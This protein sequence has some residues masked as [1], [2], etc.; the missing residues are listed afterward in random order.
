M[1]SSH[2][3]G[4]IDPGSASF[5]ILDSNIQVDT[6]PVGTSPN[7]NHITSDAGRNRIASSITMAASLCPRRVLALP[8]FQFP[9]PPLAHPVAS[10]QLRFRARDEG[11]SRQQP[12]VGF[13]H[14]PLRSFH[15]STPL[16]IGHHFDTLKFVQRLKNDGF[17]EEQAVALMKILGDVMEERSVSYRPSLATSRT[18][19]YN[20]PQHYYILLSLL[21]TLALLP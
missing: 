14:R 13:I 8:R 3:G 2:A 7:A 4:G 17:T 18:F 21:P 20:G 12:P 1:R 10:R 5:G 19:F 9:I 6:T 15:T 16:Q 11:S